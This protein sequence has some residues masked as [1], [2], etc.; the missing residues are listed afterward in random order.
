MYSVCVSVLQS[1]FSTLSS[2]LSSKKIIKSKYCYIFFLSI[3]LLYCLEKKD[4]EQ[5]FD[6]CIDFQSPV[7]HLSLRD[8]K[9][10]CSL[11]AHKEIIKAS[12]LIC[13]S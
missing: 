8:Y 1:S 5:K 7:I 12:D 2:I 11:I 6:S 3:E 4:H 9:S 10:W 13:F